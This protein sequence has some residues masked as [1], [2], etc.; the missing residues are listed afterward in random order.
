MAR[1]RQARRLAQAHARGWARIEGW[2]VGWSV[3]W[4]VGWLDAHWTP[5]PSLVASLAD[6]SQSLLGFLAV[7]LTLRRRTLVV[8]VV[9]RAA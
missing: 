8:L 3:G 5:S 7:R 6:R 9:S 2:L 4:L 1:H